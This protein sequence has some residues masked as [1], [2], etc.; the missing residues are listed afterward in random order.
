LE[1][2]LIKDPLTMLA[3]IKQV[4]GNYL[5]LLPD[6]PKFTIVEVSQEYNRATF[7]KREEI[8]GKGIFEVFPDNPDDPDANGVQKMSASLMKVIET[9]EIQEMPVQKYAVLQREMGH[10]EEK[11]WLPVNKPVFINGKVEYIV[12]VAEDITENRLLR[13]NERY[14]RALADDAPFM[15]WRSISGA[16]NY[17]NKTWSDFTGLS[18]QDSLGKGYLKAFYPDDILAQ[19]ILFKKAMDNHSSYE[20]KY[21]IW[22]KDGELR[23]V[24]MKVSPH[25]M[26]VDERT[27]EYIGSM[28]DI[29]E[30]EHARQVIEEREARFR[31]MLETLPQLTWT[32]TASGE[33][34]FYNRRWYNYTGLTFK[35]TKNIGWEGIVHPDDVTDTRNRVQ[36]IL[37]SGNSVEF[38]NRYR[39]A[40]GAY[41]WHLNRMQPYRNENG[42]IELWVATATDIHDLKL[43]QQRKDDFIS[44]ASHELRTPITS[45]KAAL[46][47]LKRMKGQ[48]FTEVADSIIDRANLSVDKVSALIDDLLQ[49]GKLNEGQVQLKKSYFNLVQIID[50]YCDHVRL[51]GINKV[52]ITGNKK[53]DVYAD[54]ERIGQVVVNLVNNALKHAPQSKEI[55]IHIEKLKNAAKIS[56]MDKGAGIPPEKQPHLFDRYYRVDDGDSQPAGLGL[57]LYICSEI[58][59]KHNGEIGVKSQVGKGSSFW[60]KIPFN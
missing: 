12:H 21:R 33:I 30:Q 51:E 56:V 19:L 24:F 36:S 25:Y 52:I 47:V 57:G 7:T 44:I 60:F 10:F 9:G 4:P 53:L 50:E 35:E 17:I 38:E 16:C 54:V 15:V 29:T 32:H 37:K 3:I 20:S 8:I 27:V 42:E 13:M 34:N 43:L 23:W 45:L 40:D 46:Q 2:T 11:F 39:N 41:R 5:I 18:L 1:T 26:D 48:P 49:I 14:F 22:R 31:K 6:Y 55:R 28:I 59:K 58:I